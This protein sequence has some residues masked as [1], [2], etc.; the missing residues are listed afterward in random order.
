MEKKISYLNRTY[1]DYKSALIDYS[2]KYY[3]DVNYDYNDASVGDWLMDLNAVIADELSY[4]IDK[5]YQETNINSA[6]EKSSIFSIARNHGF[7]IP[8]PKGAMV[9]VKFTCTLPISSKGTNEPNW[10]YAPIIKRGTKVK[11]SSQTFE[12]LVDVD[13]SKQFN[14]DG[15]SDRTIHPIENSNG[16]IVGYKISKLVVVIAGETQIYKKVVYENEIKPFMEILIPTENVMN[17]ESI[18]VRD[19]KNDT[20]SSYP[21]YGDFFMCQEENK[22]RMIKR[23]F[24]VDSLAQ[25]YRWCESLDKNH[26]PKVFEYGYTHNG[27]DEI[28]VYS[29][30]RGEWKP[31]KNKFMTEYTDKGYMKVIFGA[32]MDA[33]IDIPINN[34]SDFSKYQISKIIQNNSLGVLPDANSTVFIL[35]RY[36]GGRSSNVAAGAINYIS[37]L[38]VDINVCNQTLDQ[39]LIASVKN[40]IVVENTTPSVSGKDM[41]TVDELKYMIKYHTH[42]QERCVTVKD[43][44][45]R[46]LLLPPKY[47]TPFRVGAIEDN[48]KIMIYLLGVDYNGYLD[49]KLPSALVKNIQD[50]L[51]E[52]RMI[53][54]FIEIKSGRIINLSF[55]VD[56]YIDKN[57]NKTDV[58]SNVIT[59][60]K[61][62]MSINRHNMGDDIFVGDIQK[63]ISKVDGVIN[64]IDLRV[65]NEFGS[66]YSNT[67]TGQEVVSYTDCSDNEKATYEADQYKRLR[68]D[69]NASDGIIYSDGDTMLEVKYD[70][71]IKIRV[72]E[73]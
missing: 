49:A 13:F 66:G 46:I 25:P 37:Y 61:D 22:D 17:I 73:R 16:I 24:E 60:I 33:N 20:I 41:P 18:I 2:K 12:L 34:A 7:K 5:V 15:I 57:Y 19:S 11:S 59:L 42:A 67:Q 3:P 43:Y 1:N 51:V 32:G 47:G 65:Y 21:T 28:P 36:G 44:I 30:T 39:N 38:N 6:K 52:Y 27:T 72:K 40:S 35:Y 69:L 23:F 58:V 63:E 4:H 50:Y 9:E 64:L 70:S 29:I 53:N 8:G 71:D 14:E 55:E 56:L 10:D 48:N 26:T 45:D 68:L 54:D 62:Y 31:L